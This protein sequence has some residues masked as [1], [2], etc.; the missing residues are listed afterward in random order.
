MSKCSIMGCEE[1]AIGKAFDNQ[2]NPEESS[3]YCRSHLEAAKRFGVPIKL[4]SD[5]DVVYDE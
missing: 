3:P 1:K 4:F 5:T 2:T